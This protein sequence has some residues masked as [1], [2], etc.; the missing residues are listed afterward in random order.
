[1]TD[2]ND[3][4]YSARPYPRLPSVPPLALSLAATVLFT[5]GTAAP[6]PAQSWSGDWCE[7]ADERRNQHCEVR[8]LTLAIPDGALA[9]NARPNGGIRVESWDGG[10]VRVL[11]RIITRAGSAGTA[12]DLADEVEVR[13]ARGS[14]SSHGPRTGGRTSWSVSFRVLVPQGTALDLRTTNGGI[15]VAGVHGS[16]EAQSSNGGLRLEDTAGRVSARTTN[17]SITATLSRPLD[18]DD[19]LELRTT[20]GGIRLRLPD[21][22]SARV[23]ASTTNGG[24]STDF[25]LTIQGRLRRTV[26]GTLGDGGP[27]IRATTT[28]GAI[29]LTRS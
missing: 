8:A 29:R 16:V 7:E 15:T 19:S 4:S 17:G 11:A 24:I 18:A 14:V 10:E 6:A 12:R 25:P 26:N 2:G 1:M 13:A 22:I 28:N 27:L 5:L 20:N 3:R 9:V 23:E 21:G